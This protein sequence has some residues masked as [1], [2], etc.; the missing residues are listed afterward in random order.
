MIITNS[1]TYSFNEDAKRLVP[2]ASDPSVKIDRFDGMALLDFLPST[3]SA[4][5]E[6]GLRLD[7]DEDGIG[8]QLRFQ[9]W[10]DLVDKARLHVS[11]EQCLADNEDEWNDLVARHHA[12]IGKIAE[13]KDNTDTHNH[14]SSFAFDY[15]TE[16]VQQDGA[17]SHLVEPELAPL[18]EENILDHLNELSVRD[19]DVLDSLGLE[20]SIQDYYRLLRQAKQEEDTRVMQLKVTAVNLERALAGK[21]PL[22]SSEIEGLLNVAGTSMSSRQRQQNRRRGR[23]GQSYSPTGRSARRSSPSYEPYN[24]DSSSSHSGSESPKSENVEYIMEYRSTAEDERD[25]SWIDNDPSLGSD[26]NR[27]DTKTPSQRW[28]RTIKGTSALSGSSNVDVVSPAKMSLA[29]KLK[30]RMRQGLDKSSKYQFSQ[31]LPGFM[32]GGH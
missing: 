1:E 7:R 19:R 20:Y 14:S 11:E 12:L 24:D 13:K 18:E 5:I 28:Q 22:K 21:K 10:H 9:R 29:E 3:T 6:S 25:H 15:G 17:V 8:N 32:Y 4:M 23:R 30:Q 16:P 26:Y 31:L 2:W 27:M